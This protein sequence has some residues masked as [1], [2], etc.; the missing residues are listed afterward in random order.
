[1]I[2]VMPAFGFVGAIEISPLI[3]A[4]GLAASVFTGAIGGLLPAIGAIRGKVVDEL[5][6]HG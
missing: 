3:M 6:A 4:A 2:S 1:M 5:R